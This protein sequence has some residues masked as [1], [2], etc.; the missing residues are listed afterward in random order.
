VSRYEVHGFEYFLTDEW[1]S[2]MA[3]RIGFHFGVS[4]A[5]LLGLICLLWILV[6]CLPI[7]K[8][9]RWMMMC[10]LGALVSQ[11]F[12]FNWDSGGMG[13]TG[14]FRFYLPAVVLFFAPIILIF[15]D[16]KLLG[17]YLS[18]SIVV[19]CII[20]LLG[21]TPKLYASI[22][23]LSE[24]DSVRNFN[25]HYDA[26]I[27]LP[28]R[29]LIKIA[30]KAGVLEGVNRAIHINY[31]TS[32]NQPAFVYSDLLVKYKLNMNKEL[33]CGC[34]IETP[35]VLAP[36]VYMSGLNQNLDEKTIA[37]IGWIPQHYPRYVARWRKVNDM[38]DMCL[39]ELQKTC[40]YYQQEQTSDGTV[41]GA[42]GVGV[43]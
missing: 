37:D 13:Y 28:I 1:F 26:P 36:F 3:T 2:E 27:Y 25:E 16:K 32:W 7:W 14:Y 9:Y 4:G 10:I 11:F 19:V 33:K 40:Q 41:V 29:S 31:V 35:S 8:Q 12:L 23:Q 22:S 34:S 39:V 15:S 5:I 43:K 6:L 24:P 21:N 38:R 17:K 42:I 18:P 20:A 30:E